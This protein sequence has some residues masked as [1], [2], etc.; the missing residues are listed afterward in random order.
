M[1]FVKQ[2]LTLVIVGAVILL[3]IVSI[4]YPTGSLK[5][6]L[7]EKMRQRMTVQSSVQ[8]LK[9]N[10]IKI[11]G[12]EQTYKG[13]PS[14]K[15]VKAKQKAIEYMKDQSAKVVEVGARQN[16]QGRVNDKGVPL[17][18][19]QPQPGYL[20][21]PTSASPMA[22]KDMYAMLFPFLTQQMTGT[23]TLP[24]YPPSDA[25]LK[26][27]W[28]QQKQQEAARRPVGAQPLPE[29]PRQ[30][31]DFQRNQ[32][33][34]RA[35]T[36]HMYVDAGAL[37]QRPWVHA[38]TAPTEQD[39]FEGLVDSWIQGDIVRA[40]ETTNN[41]AFQK[42]EGKK[43][44][45]TAAIKRLMH[46]SI[47][48]DALTSRLGSFETLANAA[49][50]TN[51]VQAQGNATGP[52]HLF[53]IPAPAPGADAAAAAAAANQPNTPDFTRSLTGRASGSEF[54]VVLVQVCVDIDPNYLNRFIDQ[55]Y[56]QNMG[57]TVLNVRMRAVDPLSRTSMGFIYGESQ[58]IEAEITLETLLFREWTKPLMPETIRTALGLPAEEAPPA[59]PAPQ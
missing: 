11:P 32:V 4:F 43:N 39:I 31:Y 37:Q 30:F 34:G 27:I 26:A 2:N 55:I 50:G 21:K 8:N 7:Q 35:A 24:S 53:L 42:A 36:L 22:F 57:Y 52:T 16:K 54:D 58:V 18:M 38:D 13:V 48:T 17:F 6:A 46:I 20:P 28:D 25:D 29:D 41:E 19:G 47:G 23:D 5:A 51:L 59:A 3:A 56:R 14:E 1:K 44:V 9:N 15:M 33:M 49:T 10:E 45:G 12:V 40:I